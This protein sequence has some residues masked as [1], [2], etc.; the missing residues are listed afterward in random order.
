MTDVK[1]SQEWSL[2][3]IGQTLQIEQRNKAMNAFVARLFEKLREND[4]YALLVKGQGIAQCYE[5]PLWRASGDVDLFVPCEQVG[6]TEA[7]LANL[8]EK[9]EREISEREH[10]AYRINNWEVELHGTLSSQL[11]KRI[12]NVIDEVQEDTFQKKHVRRWDN[13]GTEVWIPSADN[14]TFFVFTH[15]LQ[16]F[17][18][19]GIGLRQICDWCRLLWVFRDQIDVKLLD[20]RLNKAGIRNEWLTFASLAV[21]RLGMPQDAIPLYLAE[22][23]WTG[24]SKRVLA[25]IL[26]TGNFGHNRD[27][28]YQE[29]Y[30]F[31]FLEK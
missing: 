4:I 21:E 11:G 25:L 5:R 7:V 29:K 26:E 20:N 31:I 9:E 22:K 30:G 28:S 6:T 19:G 24:K 18:R 2:Q 14:D 15:I 23:K 16:H 8:S 10:V 3:F 13:N 27:I 12:D 1:V 17:F